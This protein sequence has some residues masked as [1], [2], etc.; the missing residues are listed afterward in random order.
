MRCP[1]PDMKADKCHVQ[2]RHTADTTMIMV[3]F[4]P[5]ISGEYPSYFLSTSLTGIAYAC[6]ASFRRN[7]MSSGFHEFDNGRT[8]R[9]FMFREF[10]KTTKK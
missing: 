6:E 3:P 7:P 2:E 4:S 1:H 8:Q 5:T 9:L 10:E